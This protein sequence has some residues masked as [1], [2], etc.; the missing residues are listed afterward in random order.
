MRHTDGPK[1]FLFLLARIL[2]KIHTHAF[3]RIQDACPGLATT[4]PAFSWGQTF[5]A[6]PKDAILQHLTPHWATSKGAE[7]GNFL[8]CPFA[9]K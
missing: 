2:Y 1:Q 6:S 9:E 4:C 7:S 5:L 8:F 3:T